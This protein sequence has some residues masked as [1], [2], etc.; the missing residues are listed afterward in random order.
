MKVYVLHPSHDYGCESIWSTQALAQA[1][2]DL[3][4]D[5]WV[6]KTREWPGLSP[7][8]KTADY[9][10]SLY[11]ISEVEIDRPHPAPLAPHDEHPE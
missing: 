8:C 10:R 5:A 11:Y 3:L 9:L 7:Q 4:A 6:A 2:L 1:R